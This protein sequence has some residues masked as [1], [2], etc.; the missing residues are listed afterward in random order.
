MKRINK[1]SLRPDRKSFEYYYY[2]KN[3]NVETLANHWNV[4][5]QTVYN[6]AY[7]YRKGEKNEK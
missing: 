3:I 1:K 2:K 6:W 4:K 7:Q 5:K